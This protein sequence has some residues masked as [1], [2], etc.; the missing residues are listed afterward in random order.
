[1]CL[2]G[3]FPEMTAPS[4]ASYSPKLIPSTDSVWILGAICAG[5]EFGASSLD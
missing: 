5:N 3:R 1:M 2:Y 4:L